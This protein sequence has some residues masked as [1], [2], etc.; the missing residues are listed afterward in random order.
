[1]RGSDDAISFA[2]VSALTRIKSTCGMS[3][4]VNWKKAVCI[5]D[6][7]EAETQHQRAPRFGVITA[8]QQVEIEVLRE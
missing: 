2:K 5:M 4:A 1:M 6:A 7:F 8:N 3:G